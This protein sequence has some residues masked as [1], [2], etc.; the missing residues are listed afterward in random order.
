MSD[1][2]IK[3][4]VSHIFES[5]ANE[6]R[7]F[8]LIKS[9]M[10]KQIIST[11]F[12]ITD[13]FVFRSTQFEGNC[14]AYNANKETNTVQVAIIVNGVSRIEEWDLQHTIWGFERGDYYKCYPLNKEND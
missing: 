5:G 11:A 12:E 6:I 1:D 3:L 8:E 10:K 9:I 4:E 2:Q 7:V 13:W 14:V